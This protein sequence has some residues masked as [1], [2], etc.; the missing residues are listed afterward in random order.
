MQKASSRSE[1]LKKGLDR[2]PVRESVR[3]RGRV[4]ISLRTGIGVIGGSKQG[5]TARSRGK[6]TGKLKTRRRKI[7]GSRGNGR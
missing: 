6:G 2:G 4:K 3:V 7:R 5:S 1:Q